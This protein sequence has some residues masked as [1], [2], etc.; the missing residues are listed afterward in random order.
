MS[1][2]SRSLRAIASDIVADWSS[3]G[4]GIYFGAVP[5]LRA[6]GELDSIDDQY[7]CDDARSVVRYFLANAT[8][9]RGDVAR[10]VK[11]ELRR[12]TGDA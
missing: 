5:Y 4:K 10:R 1:D 11:K 6:M 12:L 2:S 9:W 8:T 3:R 7:G